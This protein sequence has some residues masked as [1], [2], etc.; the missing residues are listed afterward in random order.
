VKIDKI[1]TIRIDQHPNILWVHV[2]TDGGIV[3]LGE[4]F[5]GARAVEAY[6]HETVAPRLLGRDPLAIDRI[7]KDLTGYLGFAS[8][9][10]ETRGNSAIDIALWDLF[11]KAAGQPVAQLLGGFSRSSIR[12]YNT[13]AG[14]T[15][16]RGSEGQRTRNYGLGDARSE[17]DDLNAFLTRADDLAEDLLSEGITAMKIWPFDMAAEK[18]DGLYIGSADLKVALAPF[19]KIRKRVGDR[20]DVMVEFHSMWQLLPAIEIAKALAPYG[21]FWHE[22]PIRMDSLGSLKRYA[23][24]S[25]APICASETLASRWAFRD[26]LETGAAGVIMLD[27]SWC[28][29]F[30][31]ARKIAAMAEAWHLP[32]APHDCTGPVVLAASTHLSLNAPNALVQESVRAY[33][34]TWYRD[35]VTALPEVKDGMITVPPGPGLGLALVPDLDRRFTV[36]RKEARAK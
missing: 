27:L 5:Y 29:G 16:M 15:Y 35:L 33:Y 22:D 6:I 18:S 28:G 34:R 7:A 1:E 2:Y 13:C 3:G 8:S 10:V 23:D 9:G 12:T 30:S 14:T 4:T 26:L 36:T 31:E 20:M 24:A 25:P 11:G 32:I 19:E 21:T 17:F